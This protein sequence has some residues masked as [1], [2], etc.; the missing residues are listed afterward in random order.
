MKLNNQTPQISIVIPVLNEE[1]LVGKLLHHL[2]RISKPNTIKEILIVD[3]GSHDNTVKI[4]AESGA[5]ILHSPIG[6]AKQMNFGAKHATGAILYFLHVDTFPPQ[7]Y[8]TY[9]IQALLKG[10]QAGC[11]RMTFD[12]NNPVLVFFAWLTRIN[13]TLCRGGDQSLYVDRSVFIESNGFNEKYRIY[14][15][16]EFIT[17]LYKNTNFCVVPHNVVTSARKYRDLGWFR[18]QYHFTV[19]HLKN[20]IGA[21]PEELYQYYHKNILKAA[22]N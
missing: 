18:V 17:R 2:D 1:I 22:N 19:I 3:G 10:H 5:T 16:C 20:L 12:T 15:D 7:D 13:H 9:I 14:E 21:G 8:D 6:R 4:A 11:F